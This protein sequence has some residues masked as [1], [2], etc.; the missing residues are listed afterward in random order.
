MMEA[1]KGKG[2]HRKRIIA[3]TQR[4]GEICRFGILYG[5][6]DETAGFM[7]NAIV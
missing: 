7:Y 3:R 1:D 6:I 5:Y 4:T 2:S